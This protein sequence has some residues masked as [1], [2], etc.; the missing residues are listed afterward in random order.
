MSE[1][2][3]TSSQPPASETPGRKSLSRRLARKLLIAIGALLVLL[4]VALAAVWILI[5]LIAKA[6]VEKG[7][8][9]AMG[10][11]TSVKSMSIGVLGGQAKISELRVANPP[12]YETS[13]FFSLQRGQVNVTL[14]SLMHETVEIP[15]LELSGIEVNLEKKEGKANYDV[16]LANL[17]KMESGTGGDQPGQPPPEKG[18][19]KKFIIRELVIK[20]VTARADLII[21]QACQPGDFP[22]TTRV[23]LERL[24]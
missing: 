2:Q 3:A 1:E 17:K 14:G 12:G 24:V 9:M 19:G 13:H 7:G 23:S 8:T 10:V 6:A 4:V 20:D 18:P 21:C 16:I 15:Y 11:P 22:V 5:D